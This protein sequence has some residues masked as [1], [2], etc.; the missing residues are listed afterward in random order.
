MFCYVIVK[1]A[2]SADSATIEVDMAI[3]SMVM[4]VR[5]MFCRVSENVAAH[6]DL[7]GDSAVSD[8]GVVSSNRPIF[9]STIVRSRRL[10]RLRKN[11]MVLLL[12]RA[13]FQR[14]R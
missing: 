5:P 4:S 1:V 2:D 12:C 8:G 11:E 3:A 9:Y 14:S 13:M 10:R 6:V 7:F